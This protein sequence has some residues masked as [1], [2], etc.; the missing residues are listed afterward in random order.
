MS[1]DGESGAKA[2]N[3]SR[4]NKSAVEIDDAVMAAW[5]ACRESGGDEMPWLALGYESKKLLKLL[6][7]GVKGGYASL[8][9]HL[10]EDTVTYGAF[11]VSCDGASRFVFV[12]SIGPHAGG[13]VKGRATAHTQSVENALEGT[14]RWE[15]GKVVK[16]HNGKE[17]L[18]I[19]LDNGQTFD[20]F[21]AMA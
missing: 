14:T 20:V 1:A 11:R 3:A 2:L 13:M 16:V 12:A 8:R 7:T 9:P 5:Q 6:G 19:D 21:D 15:Y 10:A 4:M 18:D 17:L